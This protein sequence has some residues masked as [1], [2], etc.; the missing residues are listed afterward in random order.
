MFLGVVALVGFETVDGV[1]GIPGV[2]HRVTMY[3]GDDGGGCDRGGDGVTMNDRALLDRQVELEGVDEKEVGANVEL[4]DRFD[5]GH[6]RGVI[7]VD[8]IDTR[9]VDGGDGPGDG[10]LPDAGGE[11]LAVFFLK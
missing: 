2:D 10:V 9:G 11:A 3:F 7:D 6:A 4:A 8:L 1:D 5:H